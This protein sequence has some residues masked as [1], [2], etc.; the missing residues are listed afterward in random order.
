MRSKRGA[1]GARSRYT[2]TAAAIGDDD[3]WILIGREVTDRLQKV[4]KRM[5]ARLESLDENSPEYERVLDKL[6]EMFKHYMELKE[7]QAGVE[8]I[9]TRTRERGEK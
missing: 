6:A 1:K 7:L 3:H 5:G 8:A 9:G 4:I 2:D